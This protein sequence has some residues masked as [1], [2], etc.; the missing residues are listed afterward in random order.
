MSVGAADGAGEGLDVWNGV[1]S[2]RRLFVRSFCRKGSRYHSRV[3]VSCVSTRAMVLDVI[4][5]VL[6]Y[7]GGQFSFCRRAN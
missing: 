7:V 1:V 6:E 5:A 3:S 2:G 4:E